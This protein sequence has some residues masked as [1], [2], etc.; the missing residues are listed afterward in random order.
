M[1]VIPERVAQYVSPFSSARQ[2]DT[3]EFC[4]DSV[5]GERTEKPSEGETVLLDPEGQLHLGE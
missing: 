2:S 3:G 5:W 1:K 4:Q